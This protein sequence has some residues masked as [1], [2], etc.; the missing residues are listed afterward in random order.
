MKPSLRCAVVD[1]VLLLLSGTRER[2]EN[3]AGEKTEG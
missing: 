1:H 2:R 3:G